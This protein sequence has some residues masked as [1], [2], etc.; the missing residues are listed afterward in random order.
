[1]VERVLKANEP[2]YLARIPLGR[3]A[4]PE[5]VARVVAFLASET[6][7]YMTGATVDVSGGM[8]MR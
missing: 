8:L 4:D 1:M 6:A 2:K 3:I 7:G 5:E